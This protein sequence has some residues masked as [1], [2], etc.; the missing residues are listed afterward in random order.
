LTVT[1]YKERSK[2][3]L[4]QTL[5]LEPTVDSVSRAEALIDDMLYLQRDFL[6]EFK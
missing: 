4:L 2:I 5:L 6:P 1:A 3:L